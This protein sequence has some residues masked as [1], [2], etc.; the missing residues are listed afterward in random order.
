MAD[1]STYMA[2]GGYASGYIGTNATTQGYAREDYVS[3]LSTSTPTGGGGGGGQQPGV[4][5]ARTDVSAYMPAPGGGSGGGAGGAGGGG[6]GASD[7]S[8]YLAPH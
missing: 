1:K 7:T 3:G 6:G 8:C 5:K 4:F 2:A